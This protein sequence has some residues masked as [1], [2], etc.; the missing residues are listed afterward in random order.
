MVKDLSHHIYEFDEVVIGSSLEALSYSYFSGLPLIINDDKKPH[1]FEFFE[2][3]SCLKKY[4]IKSAEYELISSTGNK[5]VGT[6]KLEVWERLA[7]YLSMCGL[8]P[9]SDKVFSTRIENNDL[10]KIATKNSRVARFK[11]NKLRI[12]DTENVLGLTTQKEVDKFKV[13]DWINVRS[14]MIHQ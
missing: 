3:D 14:G 2:K 9:A 12:F 5:L 11:F 10:L 7:F 4:S 6:S 8:I 1:F 13:I